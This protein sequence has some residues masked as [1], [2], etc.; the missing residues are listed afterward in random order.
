MK[1]NAGILSSFN[2]TETLNIYS[3]RIKNNNNV[4][5]IIFFAQ[6]SSTPLGQVTLDLSGNL[7]KYGFR[8][9]SSQFSVE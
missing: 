1:Q 9:R 5:E 6:N 2:V 8:H 7:M 3:W 4:F